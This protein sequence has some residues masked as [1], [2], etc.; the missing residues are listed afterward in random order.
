MRPSEIVLLMNRL[1]WTRDK[2]ASEVGVR[3]R[4]VYRWQTGEAAPSRLATRRLDQIKRENLKD[5]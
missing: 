4:T 3:V 1:G 2:L 5:E